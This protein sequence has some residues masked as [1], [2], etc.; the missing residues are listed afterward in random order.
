M[1]PCAPKMRRAV[2]LVESPIKVAMV[3]LREAVQ[4]RL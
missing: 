2:M 3:D 1:L 4:Q